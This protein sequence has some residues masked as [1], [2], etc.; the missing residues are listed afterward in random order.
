MEFT[1]EDLENLA[2]L[3]KELR[4]RIHSIK[5]SLKKEQ[6]P[7][8]INTLTKNLKN[9]VLVN[10]LIENYDNRNLHPKRT[11]GADKKRTAKKA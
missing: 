11:A 5:R 10:T 3:N 2:I 9:L 4:V 8:R 1:Q 6:D 7:V